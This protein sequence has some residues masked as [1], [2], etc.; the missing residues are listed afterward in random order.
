MWRGRVNHQLLLCL[1]KNVFSKSTANCQNELHSQSNAIAWNFNQELGPFW[2]PFPNVVLGFL[3]CQRKPFKDG[4]YFLKRQESLFVV[5]SGWSLKME[6]P[7]SSKNVKFPKRRIELF[8]KIWFLGQKKTL[9]GEV[10]LLKGPRTLRVGSSVLKLIGI[11]QCREL[12]VSR[13]KS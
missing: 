1:C 6:R 12:Q 2:V 9:Q 5:G 13:T 3:E 11:F 4:W 10:I 8:P 7:T